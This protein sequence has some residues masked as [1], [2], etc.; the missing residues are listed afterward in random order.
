M[1][2]SLQ[3]LSWLDQ[4]V[5]D[6]VSDCKS[7]IFNMGVMYDTLGSSNTLKMVEVEIRLASDEAFW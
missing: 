7:L 6:T 4:N 2:G 5:I 1:K 3:L